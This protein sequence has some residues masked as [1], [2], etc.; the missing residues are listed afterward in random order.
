MPTRLL[1]RVL[2]GLILFAAGLA[3]AQPNVALPFRSDASTRESNEVVLRLNYETSARGALARL[4]PELASARSESEIESLALRAFNQGQ[5]VDLTAISTRMEARLLLNQNRMTDEER[6]AHELARSKGQI[7]RDV[8]DP[9]LALNQYIVVRVND[10]AAARALVAYAGQSGIAQ[11]A[12][13]NR[14]MNVSAVP[15]DS[16]FSWTG[17]GAPIPAQYQWGMQ[18][19]MMNFPNAWASAKGMPLSGFSTPAGQAPRMAGC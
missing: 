12:Q 17:A 13:I 10:I 15:S 11:Y 7:P 18:T 8:D 3:A 2:A 6:A 1:R 19:G 9:R 4:I 5:S 14:L 16:F